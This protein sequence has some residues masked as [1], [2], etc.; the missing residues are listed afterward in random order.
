MVTN[1]DDYRRLIASK[2]R[3]YRGDGI[4]HWD[5]V[6]L[7]PSL[8]PHQ[9]HGV[10]FA[11]RTGRSA[12]FYDTGLGKTRIFL[13]F[14]RVMRQVT[15]RPAL[16]LTPIA[17]G[18]QHAR[19]AQSIG[20]DAEVCRDGNSGRHDIDI[21]NYERLDKFDLGRYGTVV[22][23]ESSVLKAFTGSTSRS[24]IQA[25]AKTPARLAA[26]ATPAPNDYMELGQHCSF[27]GVME[28]NEML[29]RWFIAD[30]TEMGRYR[31]KRPAI[32]DFWDWVSSW[33]RCVSKPSD[34]GF[35]D[36]GYDL[37]PLQILRAVVPAED[38]E[39]LLESGGQASLWG[40]SINATSI[41]KS[42][43]RSA[44]A[45]AER[46]AEILA[47][48]PRESWIVWVDTDYEADAIM[49]ILGD[50]AIEV[51]GS[52]DPDEKEDR[53]MAFADQ[54][55]RILVSKVRICGFGLNFQHCARQV[56]MG[57][58]YSYE[59]F[60]QAVRRS[61]RFGQQRPV[62]VW[63]VMAEDEAFVAATVDR[64]AGDH[65]AMK[66]E[67][68]GAMARSLERTSETLRTYQPTQNVR[69]PQ[70]LN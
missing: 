43:R 54:K 70:W 6:E 32:Q 16:V 27:L 53:L 13:E 66:A 69:I 68:R 25:F 46:T 50:S 37:P 52:M 34:L 67:M 63:R 55:A 29:S 8:K 22:L 65:E 28:S 12:A 59:Q 49:A 4:K 62:N 1:L 51:R 2:S 17:C 39:V 20:V 10:R 30:Q 18:R 47:S 40:A 36:A 61:W 15:G 35:D 48:E 21:T 42:K 57:P 44:E 58:S 11:L 14:A 24:L 41:H 19:E 56:F 26:T 5:S 45:R 33:A 7:H 23:D 3:L 60:Y 38:S 64:K 31:L 9:E